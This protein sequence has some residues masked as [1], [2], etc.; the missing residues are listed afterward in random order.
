MSKRFAIIDSD[1]KV[2]VNIVEG[3]Q[4]FA[5]K[6]LEGYQNC[7]MLEHDTALVGFKL[8]N[9]NTFTNLYLERQVISPYQMRA[10]LVN[11][12]LYQTVSDFISSSDNELL[13]I[14]WEY[15]VEIRRN[16]ELVISCGELLNLTKEQIDD[17]F[18]EASQIK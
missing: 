18:L 14:A 7:F 17:M 11:R 8:N 6:A 9:D 16:S 3:T 4:E 2:V 12:G 5:E 10:V 13:K 1:S 15:A